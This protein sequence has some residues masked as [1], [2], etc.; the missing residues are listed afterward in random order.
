MKIEA[1]REYKDLG[2]TLSIKLRSAAEDRPQTGIAL[3]TDV[4]LNTL[5]IQ[6]LW[7][8]SFRDRQF[9]FC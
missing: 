4:A 5:S 9:P 8:E 3:R 1:L 6:S 2:E 7:I